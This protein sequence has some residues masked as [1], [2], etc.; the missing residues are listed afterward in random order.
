MKKIL[1][2]FVLLFAAL[3]SC[4]KGY[5][6]TL[7][8]DRVSSDAVFK[9]TA[10]IM[11]VLN[12]V[13]RATYAREDQGNYGQPSMMIYNDM[14]G[15]D[16]VMNAASNG[17]YNNEYKW[18]SHRNENSGLCSYSYRLYYTILVNINMILQ[19]IDAATGSQ[20]DKN[21]IKGQALTYRAWCYFNLV[22]Y[23][24]IRYDKN[25]IPN[26]QPGIPLLISPTVEPQP[27]ATV[28]EVYAQINKDL[29]AAIPL[30]PTTRPNK[31][32]INVYVARGIKARVALTQQNWGVAAT[33]AAAARA[34]FSLMSRT[35][36]LDGFVD[37]SN[38]EWMWGI[39]HIDDQSGFFGA[40]HSYMSCNYNSTN[41]RGNPKSINMLLYDALPY[42]DIRR[43]VFEKSGLS[44]SGGTGYASAPTVTI[45]GGGGTGAT[46]I[47]NVA[48]GTVTSFTIT[49]TG[50]G[51]TSNPTVTLTGGGG[52]GVVLFP[53]IV[54][55]QLR[56]ISITPAIVPAGGVRRPYMTQK[57]RLPG[58]APATIT[59]GDVVYMR[60]A[61]MYL[62]EAEAKARNSDESGA[63]TALFSLVS[64]R[65][66]SYVL[67]TN[68]GQALIDEILFQRR[69][70]LWG[71]GFRFFDLK[72]LN[73]PLNRNGSNHQLVLAN[74]FDMPAGS[75][76]WQFLIPRA[77]L[78]ANSKVVQNPL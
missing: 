13:H 28:E 70:E 8:T 55:G 9:T 26:S 39:D 34:G 21:F 76:Q 68:S 45:T 56:E 78:N 24:G 3:S 48:G 65:N 25:N 22:Q 50:T 72:R 12:G 63:R 51:Y 59:Q 47:A 32:H 10:D 1:Y 19:N 64:T 61:E 6:D 42:E 53:I 33:E 44:L 2:L 7:P 11:S 31:S 40:F 49:N 57:F 36:Y 29:D 38:P 54:N 41:I 30:L 18:L 60:A 5:L 69:V 66:P 43:S 62:I 23:F 37:Y 35:Q 52:S 77:E 27:R 16:L 17:W 73:L 4:K 15:D 75:P 71:E 74:I 58:A 20:A 67:S 14:L 46:A